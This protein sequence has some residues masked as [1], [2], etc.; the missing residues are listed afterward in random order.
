MMLGW[1]IALYSIPEGIAAPYVARLSGGPVAAGLVVASGQAGA[2]LV[3]PAFA[4]KVGPRARLRW[5][6]PMAAC[7]CGVLLLTAF[8]PGLIISMVIFALSGTF[9]IYQIAANTAFVDCVPDERRSQAF[10]LASMGTVA[11]QGGALLMAG[12]AAEVISPALVIAVGGGVGALAAWVLALRW[13]H[14]SPAITGHSARSAPGPVTLATRPPSAAGKPARPARPTPC[15]PAA[16]V[17][18]SATVPRTS[19]SCRPPTPPITAPPHRFRPATTTRSASQRPP[20]RRCAGPGGILRSASRWRPD[21]ECA[22]PIMVVTRLRLKDPALLDEFF[23]DAVAAI[24]QAQKSAGNLGADALADAGNAWWSV[25][26]WTERGPMQAYVDSEP[27]L[28]LRTRLDHYCDEAT[29]V[30]WEQASP[31][32]PDWPTSW[33]HLTADGKAAQLSQASPDNQ[34]RNFPRPVEPPAT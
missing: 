18:R 8:H 15:R 10:G 4:R 33:R 11:S 29:F 19:G 14:L 3:A 2:V 21:Q 25:S 27:H 1:L 23:T 6:G 5:M 7:T 17:L 20:G 13:R 28:T 22:M 32:L 34:T 30:D 24:E 31:A 9:A 26:A 16:A 12:A